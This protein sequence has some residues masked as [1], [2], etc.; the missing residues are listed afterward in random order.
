MTFLHRLASIMRWIIRRDRAERD[1]NDELEAFVD[2]AA[3][4]SMRD[5]AA[6]ADARRSAGL[7]LGGVEQAK[8]RVRSARHGAWLDS[9]GRDLRYALRMLRRAPLFT[10]VALLTLAL[11]IGANT[12]IFSIVNAVILRPLGYPAP[13]QLMLLTAHFPVGP[14][15]GFRLST[16]EYVEF[17]DINRSFVEVGAFAVGDGVAGGGSGAWAGAV[18]L[19]AGD[20]PLRAR[21]ALVDENL[22]AALGVQ[23]AQGRLFAPG[24]TD[25]MSSRP[26]LGGPPVAILSHELWQSAFGGQPVVGQSVRVDGRPHD[27]I[28][29]MPP[30]FDVMDNRTEIWLP[31]GVH[32][33]IRR[34]R[35]NHPL[36]VI[37]RLKDG[38]TREAAEAELTAFLENWGDRVGAGGHV[39]TARPARP[40]DHTLRLQPLQ[41]AILGDARRAI[42]VL[43]AAAGLVLL[44]ACANLASLVLARAESRRREFAVR[45]ALGASRGRLI[46]QT[47]TEGALLSLAGGLIGLWVA[48]IGLRSLVLAYPA[49]LP[50]TSEL[51]I[52]LSVLLFALAV[53]VAT[54]V[55][56]GLAPAVQSR[57]IDRVNALKE[58]S[59]DGGPARRHY[60]RRALVT[61][62]IALA[63]ML[64]IG[65]GL[66]VRTVYNLAGVDAGF[67]P[68]RMV[69]F[70]MTLPPGSSE[71]GGRAANVRRLL[72]A[73][74]QVPGVLG[75]TAMSDLPFDRLVQRYNTGAENYTN[76]DGRPVAVVDYYQFVMS[77]YFNT[78][79]IP[80]VAGRG[81]EAFDAAAE[82]RVVII[83]E[84]L[85]N[86]LWQGRD[87][88]G[89]RV[90]PNMS[91]SIGT[92]V[93]PWHTVIGVAKD[94]KEAGVDRD[95]GAELYLFV[96]QPGPPIDGTER[97]WVTTAPKTMNIVLRTGLAAS[98]LAQTLKGA[99]RAIDPSV[100][101]VGLRD[102]DTVFDESIGRPR[103]L[104]QLL[105]AFAGLALLLAVLGTYG[106]LSFMV[107]ER[108]RE[109]GIRLAIGATRGGIVAL[110]MMEGLVISTIG[111]AT[112]LAGALGLNRLFA[113]L[114]FGV[115]P[116]DPGTLTAVMSM[117][118]T[119]AALACG[120]PAWRASR[121]DPNLVLRAD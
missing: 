65:A 71:P 104:A 80:I 52:D 20:R 82:G 3:A 38:V 12:A 103:L 23:P 1:L 59:R 86:R 87:P 39:P 40:Q 9:V 109:I 98:T 62:E 8:E 70:S 92:S 7:H 68:S 17:R 114:L 78:M 77:D 76:A 14:L 91:A 89:Q 51:T 5:G 44:I 25:A 102:M 120:L 115:E 57:F 75:A 112:G 18:N 32:P 31:I 63:V 54:G 119:V 28:G 45:S 67:D 110:V 15:R 22:L 66:L 107:A 27:I 121:L 33:V 55:F 95:A 113:S 11:G 50:R 101:I 56:F 36:Q 73:L 46:Q 53:S 83:N 42:W 79:G 43:Q 64:V 90:R 41:D 34:I 106:V 47:V 16:P 96:D 21:S 60:V 2:M 116:T 85:A 93:N 84:T 61:A 10:A 35:E 99:V 105:G 48:R 4:D 81:F 100:P 117:I 108:R 19:T 97:P 30:G 69:T 88:I 118:A 26:G 37:G 6:P 13:E 94:V 111:L 24:E 72:D 58:G 74:R 29:I 49:S